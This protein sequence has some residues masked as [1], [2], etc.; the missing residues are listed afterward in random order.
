[1]L[2]RRRL[3]KKNRFLVATQIGTR[4]ALQLT[5]LD[6]FASPGLQE[7]SASRMHDCLLGPIIS[8]LSQPTSKL[9]PRLADY[10]N[11]CLRFR[12][13][14]RQKSFLGRQYPG[15]HK[16]LVRR[17]EPMRRIWTIIGVADVAG[18]FE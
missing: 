17:G 5:A 1:M 9:P 13:I 8:S 16:N 18:S 14:R 7:A 2:D 15:W 4:N 6:H 3:A 10:S 11:Y 12:S